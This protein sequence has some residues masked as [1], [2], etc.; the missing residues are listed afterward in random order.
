MIPSKPQLDFET[1]VEY[2]F[3]ADFDLLRDTP[4]DIQDHLWA[5]PA[6]CVLMDEYFKIQQAQEEIQQLNVEIQHVVTF[7]HNEDSFFLAAEEHYSHSD[8][9][10]AFLISQH[11]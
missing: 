7:M 3:L 4:Q 8:P 9:L 10:L 2:A 6:A 1:F 5:Q 11:Y